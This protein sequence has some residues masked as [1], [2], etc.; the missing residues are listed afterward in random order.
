MIIKR[1]F[2]CFNQEAFRVNILDYVTLVSITGSSSNNWFKL[3]WLH[4]RRQIKL[5]QG[6]FYCTCLETRMLILNNYF[7]LFPLWPRSLL[8]LICWF[9]KQRCELVFPLFQSCVR[10]WSSDV[11]RTC[12]HHTTVPSSPAE[13]SGRRAAWHQVNPALARTVRDWLNFC[14]SCQG[15]FKLNGPGYLG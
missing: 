8:V 3:I 9:L 11:P 13:M 2:K 10:T 7:L 6:I 4:Q 12:L 1:V 14:P 15:T 5:I